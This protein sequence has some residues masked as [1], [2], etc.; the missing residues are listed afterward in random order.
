METDP[1]PRASRATRQAATVAYVDR[2]IGEETLSSTSAT[3]ISHRHAGRIIRQYEEFGLAR[4]S[5]GGYREIVDN[6]VDNC[7]EIDGRQAPIV[8]ENASVIRGFV[9]ACRSQRRSPKAGL[10]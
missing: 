7:L 4:I 3:G 8:P 2:V 9:R 10:P 6:I 1:R 5:P